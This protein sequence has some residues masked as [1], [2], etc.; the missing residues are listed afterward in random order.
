MAFAKPTKSA[1]FHCYGCMDK[2]RLK[3]AHIRN[4]DNPFGCMSEIMDAPEYFVKTSDVAENVSDHS[5]DQLSLKFDDDAVS[6]VATTVST[7][8]RLFIGNMTMDEIRS[9]FR[10]L[11]DVMDDEGHLLF[12]AVHN[13]T[14]GF[15]W[16]QCTKAIIHITKTSKKPAIVRQDIRRKIPNFKRYVR[17]WKEL[18]PEIMEEEQNLG[19]FHNEWFVE[20]VGL[21]EILM[22]LDKTYATEFTSGAANVMA[23]LRQETEVQFHSFDPQKP[24]IHFPAF[25]S[26]IA[27]LSEDHII[28]QSIELFKGRRRLRSVDWAEFKN[29][30]YQVLYKQ[31]IVKKQKDFRVVEW[32]KKTA[33]VMKNDF[34]NME[35]VVYRKK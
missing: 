16:I 12:R 11:L 28:H 17:Q 13:A 3:I 21:Y 24:I 27:P 10:A 30:L 18:K 31:E 25:D 23:N 19:F 15:P 26:D 4:V 2:N 34:P 7:G 33:K 9:I 8:D 1:T 29:T 20:E 6:S 22:R 5:S 32:K 14:T 35:F